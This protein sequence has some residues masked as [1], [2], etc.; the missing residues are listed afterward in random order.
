[1]SSDPQE[2]PWQPSSDAQALAD[3]RSLTRAYIRGEL[4]HSAFVMQFGI[5]CLTHDVATP[6]P[7]GSPDVL[8]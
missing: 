3:L 2:T 5:Q 1:V 7:P 4:S 8:Q 6:R